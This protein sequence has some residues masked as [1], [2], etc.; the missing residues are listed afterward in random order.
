MAQ[1][2]RLAD[3]DNLADGV[4]VNVTARLVRQGIENALQV[5]VCYHI[6]GILP[7]LEQRYQWRFNRPTGKSIITNEGRIKANGTNRA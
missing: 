1:V 7:R 5:V 6:C 2:D 4:T 3:V